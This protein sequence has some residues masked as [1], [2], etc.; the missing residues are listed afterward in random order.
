MRP[1]KLEISAF[2][3]YAGKTE[4]DMDKLGESGLYL[5]TGDTGAGK[6]TIFDAITFALY[7]RMSGNNRKPEMMRSKYADP[8]TPTRVTLTF[9]YAGKIYKIQRNPKYY[10][11]SKRGEGLVEQKAEAILE[12]PDGKQVVKPD[13]VAK[14]INKLLGINRDQFTQI[15]MIAQGDFMKLLLAEAT[16]RQKIF[17]KLFKTEY[18]QILQDR[19]KSMANDTENQYKAAEDRIKHYSTGIVCHDNYEDIDCIRRIIAGEMPESDISVHIEALIDHDASLNG[20]IIAEIEKIEAETGIVNEE[21]GKILEKKKLLAELENTQKNYDER[22]KELIKRQKA[23]EE[24][25][26]FLPELE[27]VDRYIAIIDAERPGYEEAEKLKKEIDDN[28][29][30][31]EK[32]KKERLIIEKKRKDLNEELENLRGELKKLENTGEQKEKLI[33]EKETEEIRRGQLEELNERFNEYK[34][35]YE[36]LKTEQQNYLEASDRAAML[37]EKYN[38]AHHAFLD[39]QAGI[40]ATTLMEGEPCPVCGSLA[41]PSPAE[42]SQSAP[43]KAELEQLKKE[44]DDAAETALSKSAKAGEILGIMS[45]TEENL[46][47]SADKFNISIDQ[48]EDKITALLKES[49]QK[50]A[51]LTQK[52]NAEEKRINLKNKISKEIPNLERKFEDIVKKSDRYAI[53]EASVETKV[54]E[55]S[56][57]LYILQNGLKFESR[58]KAEESKNLLIARKIKINKD[59]EAAQ[60]EY[61]RCSQ[62]QTELKGR[63]EQLREQ[64]NQTDMAEVEKIKKHKDELIQKKQKA[65]DEQ[66]NIRSRMTANKLALE[67]IREE[68][69]KSERLNHELRWLRDLS[70]T[71][72]GNVNGK[73]KVMLETY[74]QISYFDR[75]IARANSR[76][77]VMTDGQYELK[78]RREALDNRM[79]SGLELDVID[80]CNGTERSVRTLSGG[81]SFLASLAL[82]LGLSDEVQC[83]AGGI[84]IDAMFVDEGFGSL[85]G[86]TL[87]QAIAALTD[88]AGKNRLLGIISHVSTL[89]DR[90]ENQI[91]IRKNSY[92]GSHADIVIP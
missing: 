88:L 20:E 74:V 28:R 3:P 1:L 47:E 86:E 76:L 30:E 11:A 49:E 41:H 40:L 17:R 52:I 78:R 18:Y 37:E 77:V 84:Q 23:L 39:E 29:H 66:E 67:R 68:M 27:S 65:V 8:D 31:Y 51:E 58:E 60:N 7:G 5:I 43:T 25:K 32:L 54:D 44:R 46:R 14:A 45:A 42:H 79:K 75:I 6:T 85:D 16:E 38:K 91:V 4:I 80:H 70:D 87:N 19:I 35:L 15:A 89:K 13:E 64:T 9:K 21:L 22:N 26:G 69:T 72:T 82:A 83:N 12:Y 62:S 71:V 10:R 48:Q 24:A 53:E 61:F 55:S 33:H 73:E 50:I 59:I 34:K 57:R 81:E 63:I 56:N 2:G 92:D 90:I 36:R